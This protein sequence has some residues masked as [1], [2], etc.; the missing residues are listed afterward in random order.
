MSSIR[1]TD[2]SDAELER[3]AAP[4]LE[5]VLKAHQTRNY[6]SVAPLFTERLKQAITEEHFVETTK[7][8]LDGLNAKE[9]TY[10]GSLK[11]PDRMQTVWKV[12]YENNGLELLWQVFLVNEGNEIKIDGLLFL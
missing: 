7:A 10:L 5:S 6:Q 9:M 12:K 8:H 2:L 4:F 3:S 11:K 1:L